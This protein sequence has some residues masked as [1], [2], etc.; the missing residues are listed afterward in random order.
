[1]LNMT[2]VGRTISQL[3]KQ[4]DMTQMEL[5]ERLNI[6]YQAVSNWER[7]ASMPDISKLPELAQLFGVSIDDLL[8][9]S[10]EL[11]N[12]AAN[13]T[14]AEYLEENEV[15]A[16]ELSD[17]API[18]KPSQVEY[19]FEKATVTNLTDLVKLLPF[20]DQETVDALAKKMAENGDEGIEMLFP[21]VS[22][23]VADEIA[24]DGAKNGTLD[25][26]VFPFIS[27]ETVGKLAEISYEA[28]GLDEAVKLF[29][30]MSEEQLN[31][32]AQQEF[33]QN[34]FEN[35]VKMAPFLNR[36]YLSELADRMIAQ[37]KRDNLL[38]IAPFLSKKA[39]AKYLMSLFPEED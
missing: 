37:G 5:A 30:F 17:A 23:R 28:D 18:L 9:E 6:S 29:P 35:M 15:T 3:R 13:G 12:H 25:S 16:A 2:H 33:A 24:L 4:K 11:V 7:G 22:Q 34:G 31:A 38:T 1:M 14:V 8:G 26:R 27:R 39:L 20:L 36:K 19:I 32:M 10:S 21:F